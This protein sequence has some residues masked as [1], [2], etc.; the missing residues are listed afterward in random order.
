MTSK[1]NPSNQAK[2]P[3]TIPIAFIT[4]FLVLAAVLNVLLYLILSG[5]Q[6]RRPAFPTNSLTATYFALHTATPSQTPFRPGPTATITPTV[7]PTLPPTATLEPTATQEPTATEILPPYDIPDSSGLPGSASLS[8]FVGHAQ[9]Y[10]LDCE[11]RSAV[12]FARYLGNE[13]TESAFLKALPSSDDPNKGFVGSYNDPVGQIPPDSYGVYAGP[14]ADLLS[15]FGTPAE[16]VFGFNWDQVR[17]EIANGRPVIT[18]VI[19][20]IAEG[21]P[22]DYVVPS[23]GSAIVVVHYEHTAIV[24][25]YSPDT[26]TVMDGA[27]KYSVSLSRFLDSWSVLGNM[28][29]IAK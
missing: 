17:E 26:V 13:I 28:A 9:F 21:T 16:A 4:L 23:D 8:G 19:F 1:P 22:I 7:T 29:V 6:Q 24:I 27:D 18:W 10:N 12:D 11:S 20:G 15:S 25:G 14:I 3:F 5:D 2:F